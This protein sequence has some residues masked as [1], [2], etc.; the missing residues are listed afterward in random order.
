VFKTRLGAERCAAR[1]ATIY[2]PLLDRVAFTHRLSDL[3]GLGT[4]EDD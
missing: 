1:D 4:G 3:G 2:D